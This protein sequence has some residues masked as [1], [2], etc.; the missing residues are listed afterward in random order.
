MA[1]QTATDWL[2]EKYNYITWMRNRDEMSAETAD[3]LRAQYLEEANQMHK[4][5]V[6]Q[7]HFVATKK[8][9]EVVNDIFP[10]PKSLHTVKMIEAGKETHE[11]GEEYYNETFGNDD[12]PGTI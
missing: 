5:Q 7:A 4:E 12:T 11:I 9:T 3:K 1:Q 6:V 10:V 2:A 8:M